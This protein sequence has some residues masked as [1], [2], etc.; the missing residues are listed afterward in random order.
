MLFERR[1]PEG[2]S[3]RVRVWLWP[4]RSWSRSFNYV[5]ARVSRLRGT[6]HFIALGFVTGIFVSFT[7]FYGLHFIIA[8][9]LAW[10]I[11]GSILASALGTFIL[12]PLTLPLILAST[13]YLGSWILGVHDNGMVAPLPDTVIHPSYDSI[14]SGS[15][16]FYE[17]VS[18]LWQYGKPMT[19]G[20]VPLGLAVALL[21][22]YPVRK[23]VEAYQTARR[24]RIATR[25]ESLVADRNLTNGDVR[26]PLETEGARGDDARRHFQAIS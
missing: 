9:L 10:L 11:R 2:F 3:D 16:S 7:P 13:H 19:V 22:Y 14:W 12:N 4:R 24:K 5:K 8:G 1:E 20:G 17:F 25:A 26:G 15:G 6:P 23:G 21:L 18:Q